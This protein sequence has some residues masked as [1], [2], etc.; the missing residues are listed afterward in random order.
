[1]EKSYYLEIRGKRQEWG[2]NAMLNPEFVEDMRNDGINIL[3][4]VVYEIPQNT[5]CMFDGLLMWL[6]IIGLLKP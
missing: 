3:G 4:D 1:M 6:Q 5:P 2:F